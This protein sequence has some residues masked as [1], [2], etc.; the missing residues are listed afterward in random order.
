MTSA[1]RALTASDF[2]LVHR[3]FIE[4]FSDYVVKLAPTSEQLRDML[5]RRG[6][7]PELSCG[8]FAGETLVA[9]TLNG[10]DGTTGYDTGTGVIP[11]HRREGLARKTMEWSAD[12]LRR[13][14]AQ[15]YI[16]EVI[17][18]NAKALALYRDCGFV[19]T[20]R[21][22][23][24]TYESSRQVAVNDVAP[25]WDE[26]R[27]WWDVEPSW[28]NS[29][30]SI[31]RAP[32][33]PRIVGD[34]AG[35]AVVFSSGDV[36]QLAV[37]RD[38]RRRGRGRELLDAAATIAGKPLR[39]MNVDARDEGIAAFLESCGA[40]RFVVQIEMAVSTA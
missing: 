29:V 36:P 22:Q 30:E 17:E 27:E 4:S 15:R 16:L 24:W 37:A 19:E 39:I 20:R 5:T 21:L 14:G 34:D 10:F 35:Y 23:C 12:A 32:E 13:A 31:A 3:A 6:W 38:A 18:S 9:F 33:R 11:S 26:W 8:A 28:Q 25:R 7:M 2:E 1:L 40:Q